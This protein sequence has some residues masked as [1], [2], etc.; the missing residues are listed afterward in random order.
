MKLYWHPASSNTRRVVA[1]AHHIKVTFDYEL[2]DIFRGAHRKPEYLAIN[3]NGLVPTLDDG[4]YRLTESNAIMQY[5]A[6]KKGDTN[7]WPKDSAG[8]ADVAR[9]QFWQAMHFG[10]WSDVFVE[11]N[12]LKP[13]SGFGPPDEAAV[14][15]AEQPFHRFANVLN[16][17]LESREYLAGKTWTLADFGV[18][19]CLTYA[20]PAKM[21]LE[22]YKN[23]RSWY[24]RLSVLDAWKRSAP[25]QS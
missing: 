1:L 7:V 19:A 13:L 10:R 17:H 2:V 3:P 20:E 18:G 11:E 23:I 6:E 22:R 15:A 12:F 9:W 5:I 14:K 8:R 16:N 24:A 25:P 21:P 4:N